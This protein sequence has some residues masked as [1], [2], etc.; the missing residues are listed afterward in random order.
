V[1][2]TNAL[3][4]EQGDI[5]SAASAVAA[6]LGDDDLRNRLVEAGQ[7]TA[8]EWTWDTSFRAMEQVVGQIP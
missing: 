2:G 6:L 8:R 1:H 3:V 5:K 4:V 7:K